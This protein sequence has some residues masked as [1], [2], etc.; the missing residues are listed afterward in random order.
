[1]MAL[2]ALVANKLRTSLS[3]LGITI[4]IFA[5]IIVFTAVDSLELNVRESVETLGDDVIFIQK[6]P[7]GAGGGEYKWWDYIK[8]PNPNLKELAQLQK[9]TISAEASA[10]LVSGN[11]TVQY[12]NNSIENVTLSAV[13]HDY[14]KIVSFDIISGRYFSESES[15]SGRNKV[16][17]GAAIEANLFGSINPIGKSMKILG[18]SFVVTGIIKK[19]GESIVG[20]SHDTQVI[21]PVNAVRKLLDIDSRHLEPMIMVKAKQGVSNAQLKDEL[22][23]IMRSIRK[24]KPLATDDFS[25]NETSIIS[26]RLDIIFNIMSIAGLCI[27]GF[28]ILVGGFGIA[29]IMFV[30]VKERTSII[31][32]QKSL[33]AKNYFILLQF[34]FE[35]IILCMIGGAIGLLIVYSLTVALGSVIDMQFFLTYTNIAIGMGASVTIGI[36][37]GFVPAFTASRMDPV[38]AIRAN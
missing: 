5:I 32:I 10:F 25:M 13:S 12:K 34:L 19:E 28:S 3:L 11:K 37:S 9:R 14:D 20:D 4:G 31:G 7:W 18:R 35:S 15:I 38:E 16:I 30:S 6:W 29:N 27:G 26:G 33:G 17:I 23:G 1:M 36:I 2:H 22:K 21:I 8:R 24:L